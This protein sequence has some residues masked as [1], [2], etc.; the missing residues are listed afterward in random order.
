MFAITMGTD[1]AGN[2]CVADLTRLPHLMVGGVPGSGKSAFLCGVLATLL[3]RCSP[4]DLQL[5][6]FSEGPGEFSTCEGLPHL[7][8][9]P[10]SDPAA[11]AAF[12][13]WARYEMD[14]RYTR[15]AAASVR[16]IEAFNSPPPLLHLLG[17]PC[18]TGRPIWPTMPHLVA[19]F[20]GLQGLPWSWATDTLE[21]VIDLCHMSRP[22][23]IHLLMATGDLSV[24]A[25][26]S[27]LLVNLPARL[28]FRQA[29]RFDSLVLLGTRGAEEL[30]E[31]GQALFTS[32]A[33]RLARAIRTPSIA[34]DAFARAVAGSRLADHVP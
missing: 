30:R 13:D 33:A 8:A 24:A 32:P 1:S 34:P 6:L 5:F 3:E 2:P 18:G 31:P 21:S 14:R 22:V 9:P 26:P 12:L 29:S 7:V 16:N 17:S 25:L 27:H 20:D 23:G 28:S 10:T 19:I 11:A 15:L 4:A